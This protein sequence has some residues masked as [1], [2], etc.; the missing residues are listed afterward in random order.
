MNTVESAAAAACV[1]LLS[2]CDAGVGIG[3][4]PPL[5]TTEIVQ[6]RDKCRALGM[7]VLPSRHMYTGEI[8]GAQCD[9][10][11]PPMPS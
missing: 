7:G 8:V 6:I 1:L 11:K 10:T 3:P 5:T 9:P 4:R 2:G